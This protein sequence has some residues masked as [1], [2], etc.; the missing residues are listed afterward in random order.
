[1]WKHA[2]TL[3]SA[4]ALFAIVSRV[5]GGPEGEAADPTEGAT[6]IGSA[7]CKKCH[8]GEHKSYMKM[9]HAKA[10]ESLEEK[11]RAPDQKDEEGRACISCHVTGFGMGDRG[12]FVDAKTSEHLLGVQ[13]E[14]CHG[15]GS[16][17]KE[18]GQKVLDEKRK[19]FNEGEPKFIV[20]KTTNCSNCHN[21][22]ISH[23]EKY[24]AK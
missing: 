17:H 11:Y 20:R 19:T 7:S 5:G 8:L 24:G 15:P 13:C 22:H 21:P 6:F 1:M 9:K 18:A 23:A 16:K 10:W 4:F 3:V 14:A 2:T 12:G